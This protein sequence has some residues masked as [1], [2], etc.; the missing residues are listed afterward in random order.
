M[1]LLY[2]QYILNIKLRIRFILLSVFGYNNNISTLNTRTYSSIQQIL[3]CAFRLGFITS[4]Y[5]KYYANG[6]RRGCVYIYTELC[7][8]NRKLLSQLLLM[9]FSIQFDSVVSLYIYLKRG[10]QFNSKW[11]TIKLSFSRVAFICID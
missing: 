1:H 10:Y 9:V 2:H 6:R 3:Y 7:P 8:E 4:S 5:A 11:E